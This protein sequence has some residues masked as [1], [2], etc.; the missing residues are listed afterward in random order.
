MLG[1]NC[2]GKWKKIVQKF[3]STK[4]DVTKTERVDL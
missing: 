4:N 3:V 1:E 2:A